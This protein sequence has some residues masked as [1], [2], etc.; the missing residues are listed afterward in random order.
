MPRSKRS[1]RVIPLPPDWYSATRPRILARDNHACQ[2]PIAADGTTCG[3]HAYRVDHR[4]PTH[5]GG[6]DDDANLWSLC[7]PHTRQK[8]SAEGGRAAQARRPKRNRT[9]EKHPGLL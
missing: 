5:L 2:W 1:S 9:P 6:S 3:R 8:D 4:I 7:D